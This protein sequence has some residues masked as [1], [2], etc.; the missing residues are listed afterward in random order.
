MAKFIEIPVASDNGEKNITISLD[1]I[2]SIEPYQNKTQITLDKQYSFGS[3]LKYKTVY[4]IYDY[5]RFIN[6]F[7]ILQ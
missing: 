6:E 5:D 4:C 3:D 2:I 1:Y 7:A